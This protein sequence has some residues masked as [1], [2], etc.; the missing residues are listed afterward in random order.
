MK[1]I[2]KSKIICLVI[3]C[4]FQI[5]LIAQQTVRGVVLDIDS[6]AAIPYASVQ[7][8]DSIQIIGTICDESGRFRLESVPLGR[9]SF[10][11]SCIGYETTYLNNID[12]TRAKE[13]V[14]DAELKE[15]FTKLDEIVIRAERD[16]RR[17]VN[18]FATI[19]ARSFSVEETNRYAASIGDPARQALNFAGVTGNGNDL[20]NEIVVRGNSPDGFLW[21][22][23]GNEI[24]NPNHFAYLGNSVGSVSMLSSNILTTSDFYTAAFPGEFGNAVSGVFDLSFRKG[25]NEQHE[26]RVGLGFLG[27]EIA[28]EGPFSKNNG[29]SYIVNYRYSTLS[30]LNSLGI[31]VVGDAL[32][33]YQ[34]LS[35][36]MNFPTKKSG[37]FNIYGLGG[38]S[39]FTYSATENY[40]YGIIRETAEEKAETFI[41]GIKHRI[42]VSDQSYIKTSVNYSYKKADVTEQEKNDT[43]LYRYI[44]N[45]EAPS[46]RFSTLYNHK[47]NAKNTV[48]GGIIVSQLREKAKNHEIDDGIE[49][50][51]DDFNKSTSQYQSYVQW[52]WR[53]K[54]NLTLNSGFHGLYYE[55]T[56]KYSLE[57]RLALRWKYGINKSLNFGMGIHSR[58]ENMYVYLIEKENTPGIKTQPN[59]N[60]ELTKSAHFVLGHNVN[61]NEHTTLKVETYFQHLY[62]LPADSSANFISINVNDVFDYQGADNVT[63]YGTGRNYGVEVTIERFLHNNFYYLFTMSLYESKFSFDQKTFYNTQYN[64]NYILNGLIG[65]DFEI[66]SKKKN[67]VGINLKATYAGGQRYTAVDEQLSIQN[68]EIS[69]QKVP[70]TKKAKEYFKIDIGIN[71]KANLERTTHMLSLN[72]QNVTNRLNE[73]EPDFDLSATGDK[74]IKE[75]ITQSGIIPVL[76]YSIDF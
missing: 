43:Y 7:L 67:T 49:Q 70:Y 58:A 69:Y 32:P 47:F 19:S 31:E 12:V 21:R 44:E 37:T 9:R 72:I 14:V 74:I 4:L 39:W 6:K 26:S 1:H 66:G 18:D 55:F 40:G 51:Y 2:I 41:T 33:N 34:D 53:L 60:L 73:F 71:Y 10:I 61:L 23:E 3:I 68:E 20:S 38:N 63:S 50:V 17:P 42:F 11:I 36:N 5:H 24:P 64:G 65:K 52:K 8:I 75:V 46:L 54:E 27:V 28:S 13:V 59:K 56:R 30:I 22:L 45:T 76:K 57:P 16:K 15:S 25:N 29:S 48:Q 35:F 62:D